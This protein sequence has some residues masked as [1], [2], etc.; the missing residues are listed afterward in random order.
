MLTGTNLQHANSYNIRIVL[1]TIRLYAPLSRIEIARRT[2]LT[3][4]TV[5]NITKRL[6]K[7]GLIVEA[8]RLQEGRGAPAIMLKLNPD[9]AFSVGLDFDKDHLTGVLLDLSGRIRQRD[10]IDLNFPT[11]EEAMRMMSDMAHSL[12]QKEGIDRSLVW[13]LGIG[14]PGP[15]IISKGSV[16]T[17]I[18]NPQFLPGWNHVPVVQIM[19][20][21]LGLPVFLENN[22][23][24]SAIGEKWYGEGR[25]CATFF[26]VF[27]GAGLGGGLILNGEPYAGFSGNAGEIGYLPSTKSNYQ[28]GNG[29]TDHAGMHFN[30]PLLY[31]TLQQ[32][33]LSV[34]NHDDLLRHYEDRNPLIME[35]VEGAI[36]E[37]IPLIL[38]IEYLIDPEVIFFGG[39]IP[40][41]IIQ[42]FL[43]RIS[44][45]LPRHRMQGKTTT[46]VLSK[47]KAGA[48]AAAL[49]VATLP[50]Y[51]SF[52]PLSNVFM[53]Q[54]EGWPGDL[55]DRMELSDRIDLPER[56]L[57]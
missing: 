6:L 38:S 25:H 34:S 30:L 39:R 44:E 12:I 43:L 8:H 47:S 53:K 24:A 11:P 50:L 23:S 20:D 17:N 48:D 49:G 27:F 21:R 5:T 51:N 40:D 18:A 33:G 28:F 45:R 10:S 22:A 46:P 56:R 54:P 13:G 14:L 37:L 26:Y 2:H 19:G 42:Y 16:V 36:D 57:A 4:Q 41:K 29:T 31:R 1:E 55:E 15:L 32:K 9:A 35:W 52:A 7:L 3:A